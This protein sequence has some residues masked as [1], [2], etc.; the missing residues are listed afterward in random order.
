[1]NR[2]ARWSLTCVLVM[3][4]VHWCGSAEAKPNLGKKLLG[5]AMQGEAAKVQE[6][7]GQG[8]DPNYA[9][10]EGCTPLIVAAGGCA[11]ELNVDAK[12]TITKYPAE[13][14]G[15]VEMVRA[16]LGAGATPDLADPRGVTPLMCA[17]SMRMRIQASRIRGGRPLF[18]SPHG[19]GTWRS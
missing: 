9:D 7:L 1:M 15:T 13:S 12:G 4:V 3:P 14:R 17:G 19:R 8:A 10:K 2:F 5:A 16:L 6:L 18:T 11:L